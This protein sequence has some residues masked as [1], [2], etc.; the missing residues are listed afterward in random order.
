MN[1]T[2]WQD[3]CFGLWAGSKVGLLMLALA[4]SGGIFLALWIPCVLATL[5]WFHGEELPWFL[6]IWVTLPGALFGAALVATQ[7]YYLHKKHK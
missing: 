6:P 2:P 7:S 3:F 5:A 1:R 4:M